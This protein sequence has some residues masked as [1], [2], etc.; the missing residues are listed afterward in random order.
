VSVNLVTR[1]HVDVPFHN[2]REIGVVA[3]HF[4]RDASAA[5]DAFQAELYSS[6]FDV[7]RLGLQ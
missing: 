6:T 4:A 1:E 5:V 2:D 3:H 7:R